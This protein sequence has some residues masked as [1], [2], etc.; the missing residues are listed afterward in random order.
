MSNKKMLI[1]GAGKL[2]VKI[3]G[4]GNDL[5]TF[6]TMNNMRLDIQLDTVD[7]EGGDSTF[8]IDTILRKKT[9]DIMAEDA[10]FDLNIL[11]LVLGSKVEYSKSSVPI[12]VLEEKRKINNQNFV[13]FEKDVNNYFTADNNGKINIQI[14]SSDTNLTF[15]KKTL[16]ATV[17]SNPATVTTLKS[18][19]NSSLLAVNEFTVIGVNV[20][21]HHS[22][23]DT[24]VYGNYKKKQNDVSLLDIN[25]KDKLL[26]VH[27][28]HDGFFEQV[29]GT[30][31]GVQVEFPRCRIKSNFSLDMVRQQATTQSITLTVVDPDDASGS[32]GT[33]KR[34]ALTKNN[35]DLC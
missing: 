13:E 5:F 27:I 29:D 7:V 32:V 25:V 23:K 22:L 33:I 16:D 9:I 12:W 14:R 35:L 2:M 15:N 20:Y 26:T 11:K 19:D 17:I 3:P 1:K 10:K 24:D 8:A 4:C 31:Q 21:F 28:V 6:A 18:T 30:V 34:Y